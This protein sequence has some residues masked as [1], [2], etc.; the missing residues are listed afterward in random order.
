MVLYLWKNSV[1]SSQ[2]KVIVLRPNLVPATEGI[3]EF[4]NNEDEERLK[5]PEKKMRVS[6]AWRNNRSCRLSSSNRI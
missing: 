2:A 1:I 5:P 3:Y 6:K 4:S